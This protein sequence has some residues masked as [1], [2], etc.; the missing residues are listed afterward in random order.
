M[1]D[2]VTFK[3]TIC[4]TF[5]IAFGTTEW[6]FICMGR[7]MISQVYFADV[8]FL[9]KTAL[10]RNFLCMMTHMDGKVLRTATTV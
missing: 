1:A 2:H 6:F 3:F 9:A 4:F 8:F 7:N 10:I 5:F